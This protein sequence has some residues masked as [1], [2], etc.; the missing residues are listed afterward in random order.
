MP[1]KRKGGR[2]IYVLLWAAIVSFAAIIAGWKIPVTYGMSLGN[3][4]TLSGDTVPNS[5]PRVSASPNGKLNV[6][7]IVLDA[8]RSRNLSC[9]GYKRTTSPTIDRLAAQGVLFENHFAQGLWTAISVPSFMSGLYYPAM[10]VSTGN[11][12]DPRAPAPGELLLPEILKRNGYHTWCVTANSHIGP[13]TRLG[14]AFDE[15]RFMTWPKQ[16]GK[17]YLDD[18]NQV[19]LERLP[20]LPKPFFLYVHAM[21]THFPHVLPPPYDRWLNGKDVGRI[22]DG[23]LVLPDGGSRPKQGE[24]FSAQEKEQL[25][26][27]YDGSISR[28]DDA[29]GALLGMLESTGLAKNTIVLIGADHGEELGEDGYYLQHGNTTDE[30]MQ[31]P[32]IMAGPGIPEGKRVAEFTENVDIVPTLCELL[33]V[34]TDAEFDGKSLVPAMNGKKHTP[35]DFA[36][37]VNGT[38]ESRP[39]VVIRNQNYKC[40]LKNPGDEMVMFCCPDNASSRRSPQSIPAEV[41]EGFMN[42]VETVVRPRW[43][44]SLAL[45]KQYVD[46]DLKSTEVLEEL[47]AYNRRET[48]DIKGSSPP[49]WSQ[50]ANGIVCD[51]AWQSGFKPLSLSFHVPSRKYTVYVKLHAS[52]QPGGENGEINAIIGQQTGAGS[53]NQVRLLPSPDERQE[54]AGFQRIGTANVENGLL[55]VSFSGDKQRTSASVYKLR[56]VEDDCLGVGQDDDERLAQLRSMGY[57]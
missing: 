21:D 8:C 12:L 35:R 11:I 54:N 20:A 37:A 9:Y 1:E 48:E 41:R 6:I 13:M 18:L 34:K 53:Q 51:T 23:Q 30:V 46:F 22:R 47:T 36:V 3:G 15:Y 39:E 32:L 49:H 44:R 17:P 55:S 43:L 10:C 31:V 38:Y 26:G 56:L 2:R 52:Q 14:R 29:I 40:I 7:W 16:S 5:I 27:L 25:T 42:V 45:R 4:R 28:A 33:G 57:L 19:V 50:T 24:P